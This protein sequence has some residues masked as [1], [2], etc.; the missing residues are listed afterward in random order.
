ML[1]AVLTVLNALCLIGGLLFNAE[2]LNKAGADIPPKTCRRWKYTG[3][4][5]PQ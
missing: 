5:L 3:R 2:L 4:A 1:L